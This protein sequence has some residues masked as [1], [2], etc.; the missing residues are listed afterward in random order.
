MMSV[1]SRNEGDHLSCK[2]A[3]RHNAEHDSVDVTPPC[4]LV[5]NPN[6]SLEMTLGMRDRLCSLHRCGRISRD[7]QLAFAT[8][9]KEAGVPPSIDDFVDEIASAY[10]VHRQIAHGK[11]KVLREESVVEVEQSACDKSVLQFREHSLAPHGDPKQRPE[12]RVRLSM[13]NTS[14]D[15]SQAVLVACFSNHPLAQML[16]VSHPHLKVLHI[17]EA[18]VLSALSSGGKFGILTTLQSMVDD[19][20]EGACAVIGHGHSRFVGTVA[21]GVNAA[22]L[23]DPKRK[24]EADRLVSEAAGLLASKGAKAIILGCA[25]MGDRASLIRQACRNE[26]VTVTIVDGT[27]AG[28]HLL[29]NLLHSE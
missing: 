14:I 18:A 13:K 10:L 7:V 28:V 29:T 12:Q 19:I 22:G 17:L 23:E 4:I 24:T 21:A 2:V 5:V 25:A 8:A 15:Q 27:I 20:D 26:N 6:S 3:D 1:S 16:R 9:D 11:F